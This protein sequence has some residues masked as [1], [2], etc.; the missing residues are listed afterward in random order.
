MQTRTETRTETVTDTTLCP[1]STSRAD[2][3]RITNVSNSTNTISLETYGNYGLFLI[4]Y[5]VD[6]GLTWAFTR[7]AGNIAVLQP[8]ESVIMKSYDG[9]GDNGKFVYVQSTADISASGNLASLY[10]G[11][12]FNNGFINNMRDHAFEGLFAGNRNL[13]SAENLYFGDFQTVSHGGFRSMFQLCTKL[14]APPNLYSLRTIGGSGLEAM[15]ELCTS[16]TTAPDLSGITSVGTNGIRS[17]FYGCRL[18]TTVYAPKITWNT[19]KSTNWLY[20]GSASGTLYADPSVIDTIPVD[21][22][23]GCPTGWTKQSL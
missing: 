1:P 11:D 5:S 20:E 12:N 9:T 13:V 23:S 18:L 8:G 3:F 4:W 2:Y 22:A 16:L 6:D 15:F 10:V 14:T 17:M 19:G 21:S 7:T